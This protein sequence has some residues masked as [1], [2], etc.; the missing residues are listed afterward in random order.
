[1]QVLLVR[2]GQ[3][4]ANHRNMIVSHRGDPGLTDRGRAEVLRV[5]DAWRNEPILAV[6]SSPLKRTRETAE[7]FLRDGMT[8]RID[9]RLHE[10][11]FG[12]WDGMA[13]DVIQSQEN[14]RW[15]QWK[16]DPEQWAPDGG[17]A[18]SHV[19]ERM[20][21]FLAD[22]RAEHGTGLVVAATHSDCL[23]AVVL[24]ALEAPWSA[25]Q[26]FHLTNTAGVYVEWRDSH[27]QIKGY[28]LMPLF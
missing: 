12:R 15:L 6:Y 20:M 13:I 26:W 16:R 19:G 18:L 10:I 22:V 28:P 23:K 1:M 27:W 8:M 9:E 25:S 3:S 14:E 2:H 4:E 5:A 17:E 7:A 24:S 11:D 21:T